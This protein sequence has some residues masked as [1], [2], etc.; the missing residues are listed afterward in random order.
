[1]SVKQHLTS[2]KIDNDDLDLDDKYIGKIQM[3]EA[4]AKRMDEKWKKACE[5]RDYYMK[6]VEAKEEQL[7]RQSEAKQTAQF[8]DESE[9]MTRQFNESMLNTQVDRTLGIL[10]QTISSTTYPLKKASPKKRTSPRKRTEPEPSVTLTETVPIPTLDLKIA[11]SDLNLDD[12][13]NDDSEFIIPDTQVDTQSNQPADDLNESDQIIPETQ[14]T[15]TV[16]DQLVANQVTRNRTELELSVVPPTQLENET[17]CFKIK[18]E[19]LIESDDEMPPTQFVPNDSSAAQSVAEIRPKK[20][21]SVSNSDTKR[22]KIKQ[23]E[24]VQDDAV[25]HQARFKF[26]DFQVYDSMYEDNRLSLFRENVNPIFDRIL[27][28]IISLNLLNSEEE[29][30]SFEFKYCKLN[31]ESVL[32]LINLDF[33]SRIPE[34]TFDLLS[35]LNRKVEYTGQL[36]DKELLCKL[37]SKCCIVEERQ[38]NAED[39]NQYES[40]WSIRLSDYY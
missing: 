18:Q 35:N 21:R 14:I 23:P 32:T 34:L 26:V 8:F 33:S 25:F 37:T 19:T 36:A 10:D 16:D 29:L 9:R 31:E 7:K 27:E 13:Q 39:V 28:K 6:Q 3:L 17:V 20:S 11:L 5:E 40:E 12:F 30:N 2:L 1:M 15:E 4:Q 38:Y 24:I 22:I